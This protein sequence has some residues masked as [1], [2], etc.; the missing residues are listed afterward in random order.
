MKIFKTIFG[1][2]ILIAF[3]FTLWLVF[4]WQKFDLYFMI[5]QGAIINTVLFFYYF[6]VYRKF[7]NYHQSILKKYDRIFTVQDKAQ[8]DHT[9]KEVKIFFL[10]IQQMLVIQSIY[11]LA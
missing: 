4:A 5:V 8:I 11:L 10:Y 1:L 6:Y 9:T 7:F 2:L 3:V